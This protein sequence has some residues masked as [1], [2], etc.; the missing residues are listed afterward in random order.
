M[1][2]KSIENSKHE[3]DLRIER[4]KNMREDDLSNE[5]A[6]DELISLHL[7]LIR[8]INRIRLIFLEGVKKGI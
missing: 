1:T 4:E 8:E 3:S 2:V 5:L 7:V 6:I